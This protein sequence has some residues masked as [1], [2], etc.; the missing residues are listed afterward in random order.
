MPRAQRPS[1][2]PVGRWLALGV[3]TAQTDRVSPTGST[4]GKDDAPLGGSASYG[5]AAAF[6]VTCGFK[7][8]YTGSVD[9]IDAADYAA[10]AYPWGIFTYAQQGAAPSPTYLGVALQ[11]A[12]SAAWGLAP[13]PAGR[14]PHPARGE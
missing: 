9:G 14:R 11:R 1:R 10:N 13:R 3:D 8:T 2:R 5:N 7:T 4:L 6:S 12:R